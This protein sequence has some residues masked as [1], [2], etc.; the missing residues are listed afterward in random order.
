[1]ALFFLLLAQAVGL[2]F[3]LGN[4]LPDKPMADVF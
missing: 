1:V 2:L 3:T 4:I